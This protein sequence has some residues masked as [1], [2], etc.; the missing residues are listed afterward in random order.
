M[1]FFDSYTF[2]IAEGGRAGIIPARRYEAVN[3]QA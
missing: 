1:L 2:L 3:Y